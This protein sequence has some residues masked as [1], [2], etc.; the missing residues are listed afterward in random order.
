MA[1]NNRNGFCLLSACDERC[2]SA[3]PSRSCEFPF[4]GRRKRG[5][6]R[7]SQ[8]NGPP[9]YCVAE[10]ELKLSISEDWAL[11]SSAS[12]FLGMAITFRLVF[13]ASPGFHGPSGASWSRAER[14][15]LSP[16]CWW[17]SPGSSALCLHGPLAGGRPGVFLERT[18]S[19]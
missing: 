15:A 17:E 19:K 11:N 10:P 2:A 16:P 12:H 4:Y 7:K 1:R 14:R 9:G 5:S 8:W 13:L 3:H 18:V 6:E